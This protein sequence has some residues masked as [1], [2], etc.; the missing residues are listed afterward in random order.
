MSYEERQERAR[1]LWD[2]TQQV[3]ACYVQKVSDDE[4][5]V[6]CNRAF[7]R[8]YINITTGEVIPYGR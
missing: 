1:K 3:R 8:G 6:S 4:W 7:I 2:E 5:R